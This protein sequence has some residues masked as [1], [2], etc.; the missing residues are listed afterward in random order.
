MRSAARQNELTPRSNQQ[1]IHPI[2][3]TCLS[4]VEES[5]RG[6]DA[7]AQAALEGI[8]AVLSG[9]RDTFVLESCWG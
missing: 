4:V 9:A 3:T 7:V 2:G 6:G 5:I 1:T 8:R